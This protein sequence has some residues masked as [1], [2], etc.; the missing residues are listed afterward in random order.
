MKSMMENYWDIVETAMDGDNI[1]SMPRLTYGYE[2]LTPH[3]WL[4]TDWVEADGIGEINTVEDITAVMDTFMQ[5]NGAQVGLMMEKTLTALRYLAPA[6]HAAPNIWIKNEEGDIV[7]GSV[8]PEM[9]E[10]LA[11]FA[12]WFK[13]GYI[14]QDFGTLDQAAMLQDAYQGKAGVYI[15]QNWGCWGVGK[16]MVDNQGDGTYFTA[17]D[18][19]SADGENLR[20]LKQALLPFTVV[21]DADPFSDEYRYAPY[22]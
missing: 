9:K 21:R 3:I 14:R 5:T 8:Q 7:Y 17:H 20:T 4:R 18:V 12:Q 13:D 2:T 1:L 16:E 11:Q 15:Q 22:S 10:A 19:P 6:W